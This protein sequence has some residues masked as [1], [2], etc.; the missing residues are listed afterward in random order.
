VIVSI[1]FIYQGAGVHNNQMHTLEHISSYP[2]PFSAGTTIHFTL[3]NEEKCSLIIYNQKGQ[4]VRTLMQNEYVQKDHSVFW[5]GKSGQGNELENGI[6]LYR[7]QYG[8]MAIVRKIVKI[9]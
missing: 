8:K 2:I 6:Y 1:Q 9:D 4:K 7:L 3:K 5:D